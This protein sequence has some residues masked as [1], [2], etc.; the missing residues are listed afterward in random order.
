[1]LTGHLLGTAIIHTVIAGLTST[2]SGIITVTGGAV[3]HLLIN[4]QPASTLSVDSLFNTA[5]VVTAFDV[6]NNPVSGV[7]IVADRDPATGTGVLRGTLSVTTNGSGQA[8]FSNLGYNKTDAFKVRFTSNTK[9]IISTQIGPLAVDAVATITINTAPVVGASVDANLTTQPVILVVDQFSNP[10]SGVTVTASRGTGTG[11]LRGTLTA[12]SSSTGLATFT[13]LGYNKS[14]ETFTIHF[15]AGTPTI[16]SSSLG[17]LAAG[18]AAKV[19]I[20]TSANG[21][22][23]VVPAQTLATGSSLT[24]YSVTRDQY[25]NFIGNA[26]ADSWTLTGITGGVVSGDLVGSGTSTLSTLIL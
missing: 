11:T 13:N 7:S 20:E 2:D 22:G 17:P 23:T 18:V 3:D 25:S 15:A 26:T 5:A 1:V 4:T 24:V 16:D 9:A 14:G 12:T 21:S 10:V 19:N 6:G 8:T